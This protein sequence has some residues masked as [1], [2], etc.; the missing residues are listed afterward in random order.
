MRRKLIAAGLAVGA[1]VAGA[2]VLHRAEPGPALA[3]TAPAALPAPPP[4]P[5]APASAET[6]EAPEALAQ[7]GEITQTLKGQDFSLRVSVNGNESFR[8]L[9]VDM[10]DGTPI[11]LLRTLAGETG[12]LSNM[13]FAPGDAFELVKLIPGEAREQIVCKGSSL[14]NRG[15]GMLDTYTLYRIAGD[16]LQEL[17]SVITMRDREEDE[18]MPAQK[19]EASIEATTRDGQPAFLYHVK[20]GKVP[21]QTIVFLW[22]GKQFEDPSG[23]Y[24]KIEEAN[25]P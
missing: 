22:N 14:L 9:Q 8:D 12:E 4:A 3:T 10:D 23:A 20:A 1:V 16:H 17:I 6:P 18:G 19:L 25:L 15:E 2:L 5:A 24:R 11:R 13:T 21:E 7:P